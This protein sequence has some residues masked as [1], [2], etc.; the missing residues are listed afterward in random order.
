MS[1][2]EIKHLRN[3]LENQEKKLDNL[4]QTIRKL[5]SKTQD[6]YY[7]AIMWM[8]LL[9]FA[10]LLSFQILFDHRSAIDLIQARQGQ[11]T[12]DAIKKTEIAKKTT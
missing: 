6:K 9:S 2:W 4:N 12:N 3:Q 1:E 8:M 7:R 5:K 11:S 10:L